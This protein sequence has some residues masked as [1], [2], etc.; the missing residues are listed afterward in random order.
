MFTF[1]ATL[2]NRITS[3]LTPT[4]KQNNENTQG[5][6]LYR[7]DGSISLNLKNKDVQERIAKHLEGLE[8]LKIHPQE[9]TH[10]K[11]ATLKD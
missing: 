3:T 9:Q 7:P 10:Q 2:A 1:L 8:R 4:V 5:A 11:K 6:V